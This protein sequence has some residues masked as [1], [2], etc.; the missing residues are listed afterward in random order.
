MS[1][2][3]AETRM[4]IQVLHC[5]QTPPPPPPIQG[6]KPSG[7]LSSFTEGDLRSFIQQTLESCTFLTCNMVAKPLQG[8]INQLVGRSPALCAVW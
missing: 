4:N 6:Q 2:T 1:P 3:E 8:K 7:N 5:V